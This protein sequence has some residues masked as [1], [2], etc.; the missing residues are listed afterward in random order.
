MTLQSAVDSARGAVENWAGVRAALIEANCRPDDATEVEDALRRAIGA[1]ALVIRVRES[2]ETARALRQMNQERDVLL[3]AHQA[4]LFITTTGA[5]SRSLRR[6][7]TDLTSVLDL[8]LDIEGPHLPWQAV[9]DPLNEVLK[10]RH[11]AIDLTGF[12]PHT[13]SPVA[14]AM[15]EVYLREAGIEGAG[16]ETFLERPT[17][18]LAAPGSGK[19]TALRFLSWQ[20]ATSAP[21][22][23]LPEEVRLAVYVPL[24]RWYAD[25][26]DRE[27]RLVDFVQRYL[28]DLLGCGPVGLDGSLIGL[29]LLL[30]GLDE[31][32]DPAARR[33]LL[34]QAAALQRQGA[35]ILVTARDHVGDDLRKEELERWDQVALK[36]PDADARRRLAVRILESRAAGRGQ[37]PAEVQLKI[38]GIVATLSAE[39][40]L[41]GMARS[42]LLLTFLV[43][44]A[45][46]GQGFLPRQRTELYR[47]L[48]EMLLQTWRR[49]RGAGD[50]RRALGRADL[51]RVLAPLAWQLVRRGI[52]GLTRDELLAQLCDAEGRREPDR[53]RARQAAERRLQQ[54]VEDTALLRTDGL[55]RFHHPTIGEY[56]ASQAVLLDAAALDE[57]LAEPYRPELAQVI[58]FALT[59]ATDLDPRP[60]VERRLCD[61]LLARATRRGRY[62][63]KIPLLLAHILRETRSLTWTTRRDM[64]DQVLRVTLTMALSETARRIALRSLLSTLRADD[65]AALSAWREWIRAPRSPVRWSDLAPFGRVWIT[66]PLYGSKGTKDRGLGLMPDIL[67]LLPEHLRDAGLDAQPLL[68]TWLRHPDGAVRRVAWGMWAVADPGRRALA[69]QLDPEGAPPAPP[70]ALRQQDW[71]SLVDRMPAVRAVFGDPRVDAVLAATGRSAAAAPDT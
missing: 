32:M 7:A 28:G 53:E 36:E 67:A 44:L 54:I 52:G 11:G 20:V 48:V 6:H 27:P 18:A 58:T 66:H 10:A 62:D 21:E 4:I 3:R 41:I 26:R 37:P 45:D 50:G 47:D 63:S 68:E 25:A 22:R 39:P 2:E 51:L 1:D 71:S 24:A 49:V 61:S 31:V 57:V 15:G 29:A 65:D 14:L 42:P 19:T 35:R 30:D 13:G 56:L 43:V 5:E 9:V 34:A 33:G 59:T 69:S 40:E 23:L 16:T 46:L 38:A 12:L 70:S 17:L 60:E 64:V 8:H 55:Y